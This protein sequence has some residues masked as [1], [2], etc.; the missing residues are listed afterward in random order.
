M[1]VLGQR[2]QKNHLVPIDNHPNGALVFYAVL[3][4][5]RSAYGALPLPLSVCPV[6][7]L[8]PGVQ[9]PVPLITHSDHSLHSLSRRT[10]LLALVPTNSTACA[11]IYRSLL[12]SQPFHFQFLKN[13]TNVNIITASS[14]SMP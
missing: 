14:G 10:S 5:G 3:C 4:P 12:K 6:S 7:T 9:Q 2:L 8:S 13:N 1:C 11:R